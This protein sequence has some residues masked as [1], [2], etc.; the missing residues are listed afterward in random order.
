MIKLLKENTF[1]FSKQE[2]IE[3]LVDIYSKHLD[4]YSFTYQVENC[5]GDL[6]PDS[7]SLEDLLSTEFYEQF[8]LS[9]LY[10][11]YAHLIM[12]LPEEE[13][14]LNDLFWSIENNGRYTDDFYSDDYMNGVLDICALINKEYGL[15]LPTEL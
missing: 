11:L 13:F 6:D 12:Q 5:L 4:D 15:N 3:K 8:S 1:D 14:T 9:D 7:V 2:I 10:S